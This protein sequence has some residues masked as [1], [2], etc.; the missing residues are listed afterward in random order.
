MVQRVPWKEPP[1]QSGLAA[2]ARSSDNVPGA[3]G[4]F[5]VFGRSKFGRQGV[6]NTTPD[7]LKEMED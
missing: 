7:N 5:V 4:H 2:L 1:V 3:M 6:G